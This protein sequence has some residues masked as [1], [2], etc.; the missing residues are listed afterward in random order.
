[1]TY[2]IKKSSN[3]ADV[4]NFH[5]NEMNKRGLQAKRN[6]KCFALL[7]L[8]NDQDNLNPHLMLNKSDNLFSSKTLT[9]P[10]SGY[11]N[12]FLKKQSSCCT[13]IM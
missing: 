6:I 11:K 5:I 4:M 13:F 9:D 3:Q 12:I 8:N 1:M 10:C 7:T 2:C